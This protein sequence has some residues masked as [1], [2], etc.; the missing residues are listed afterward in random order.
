MNIEE[1]TVDGD[2]ATSTCR[3]HACGEKIDSYSM[4]DFANRILETSA[5]ER[6]PEKTTRKK[7]HVDVFGGASD[8]SASEEE[9]DGNVD[10]ESEQVDTNRDREQIDPEND[11]EDNDVEEE[12]EGMEEED[13]GDDDEN[14]DERSEMN[15]EIPDWID[16]DISEDD[17]FGLQLDDSVPEPP[18]DDGFKLFEDFEPTAQEQQQQEDDPLPREHRT[19][20]PPIGRKFLSKSRRPK[21]RRMI[22][23]MVNR[24]EKEEKRYEK[25]MA[26]YVIRKHHRPRHCC[27]KSCTKQTNTTMM[28]PVAQ[29]RRKYTLVALEMS[30]SKPTDSDSKP[31][32][33][34]LYGKNKT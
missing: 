5:S 8:F 21:K 7:S 31:K 4:R 15:T 22:Q 17:N 20:S 33:I 34:R 23:V 16:S 18:I 9:V 29:S 27:R 19:L 25:K 11:D 32:N 26:A 10:A 6:F 1:L 28:E 30:S 3:H 12:N 14:E 24:R 2:A 13:E